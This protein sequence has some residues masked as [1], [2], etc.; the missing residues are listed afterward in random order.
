MVLECLVHTLDIKGRPKRRNSGQ[1]EEVAACGPI[2]LSATAFCCSQKESIGVPKKTHA[3]P[4]QYF[5]NTLRHKRP[6]DLSPR[7]A[8]FLPAQC[9]CVHDAAYTLRRKTDYMSAVVLLSFWGPVRGF[10]H[11]A[12]LIVTTSLIEWHGIRARTISISQ[13]VVRTRRTK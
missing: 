11:T 13:R 8:N 10:C 2:S 9:S 4:A 6:Y 7:V 12:P 3:K 1:C 5:G